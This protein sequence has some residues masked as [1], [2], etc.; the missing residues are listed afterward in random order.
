MQKISTTASTR[1]RRMTASSRSPGFTLIELLV[2]IAIIAILIALLLPAVQQAREAARRS[3]CKNNLKQYGLALQNFHDN[4]GNFPLGRPDD[5][6]RNYGWGLYILP[7]MDQT[8]AYN[9]IKNDPLRVVLWPKGGN[10][11]LDPYTGATIA[12]I[13]NYGQGTATCQACINGNHGNSMAKRVMPFAVCPSDILPAVDNNGYGKSNYCGSVGALPANTAISAMDG[14]AC[15]T[16]NGLAQNGI[17]PYAKSNTAVWVV[18]MRDVKDGTSNTIMVGE[19]SES[20]RVGLT[21]ANAPFPTWVSA[22]NDG[23]CGFRSGGSGLRLAGSFA[24][25]NQTA[26]KINDRTS[27]DSDACF[28]SQHAG[29]AT[30]LLVDGSV[31]FI[32]QNIDVDNVYPRL[33]ARNDKLSV[34]DF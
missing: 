10:P 23:G 1:L 29:G 12:N 8:A 18:N 5:D 26:L 14:S 11:F 28:G 24:P 17:L 27:I 7:Y 15:G 30:F 9:A 32:S 21:G 34:A 2:V 4:M 20:L 19:V 25:R 13:D 6:N 16:H 22:N 31:R 33:G 3:Q